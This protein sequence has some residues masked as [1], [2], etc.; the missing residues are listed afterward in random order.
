MLL[1][2][3]DKTQLNV[4]VQGGG[5]L[6]ILVPGANGTG[7]I[8]ADTATTLQQHFTVVTYDRRG[9][10]QSK[11][12][13]PLPV[14]ATDSHSHYRI[15]ADVEDVFTLADAFSADKP[16][17][18]F[19]SS[20][21]SIV[22]AKAF[23]SQP[24][25]F[26]KVALHESPLTT[27]TPDAARLQS[28]TNQLVKTALDGHFEAIIDLFNNTMHIQPLDAQMMGL[29]PD[30]QPNP[31]KM[32]SMLFWLKYETAQYTGQIID[33]N[34]FA[35]NRAKVIL[36]NGTDSTGFLPQSITAAIGSKIQVP[37]TAIPGGHLGYAQKPAAF[38]R[39]LT[40]VFNTK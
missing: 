20:S 36:L 11:L 16:V 2:T 31:A 26:A 32:S 14:S 24:N 37:I 33:W 28:T 1:K 5:P 6:L 34:V 27:V 10:G 22:A 18:L 29:A 38:A 3:K 9:Y 30:S 13:R 25:R 19:G 4:T 17:Y 39:V 23:S 12:A 7:D 21:G 15:D 40:D 35:A 8:F